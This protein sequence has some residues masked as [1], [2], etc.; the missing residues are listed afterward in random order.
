[1]QSDTLRKRASFFARNLAKKTNE[2]VPS[3]IYT[4]ELINSKTEYVDGIF[5]TN[6]ELRTK[7]T[8]NNEE[9]IV[10]TSY[11]VTNELKSN[12]SLGLVKYY[13]D[14]KIVERVQK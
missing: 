3:A 5:K 8:I 10:N 9:S 12:R 7:I 4:H 11:V 6:L 2:T 14:T 1:M 13:W